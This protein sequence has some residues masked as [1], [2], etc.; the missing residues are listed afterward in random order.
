MAYLAL[1]LVSG[2]RLYSAWWKP[3]FKIETLCKLLYNLPFKWFMAR[4]RIYICNLG[5]ITRYD[6]VC[7]EFAFWKK[8]E[9][10][11]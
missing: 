7:R 2:L 11:R 5:R 10:D 6:A 1:Q 3:G 4:R 8:E 9:G